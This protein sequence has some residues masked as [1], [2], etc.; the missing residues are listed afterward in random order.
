MIPPTSP[1]FERTRV[2]DVDLADPLPDHWDVAGYRRALILVR[3]R[4]RTLTTVNVAAPDEVVHAAAV[5][6]M[7]AADGWA[8]ATLATRAVRSWLLD[9]D[10]D[11]PAATD[12]PPSWSVVV[13]TRDRA[14]DLRRCLRALTT[15]DVPPGAPAGEI[16]VVDNASADDATARV[17]AE[18]AA[19]PPDARGAARP[20]VRY[21]REDRPGLNWARATGARAARGEIVVYT[22][23]DVVVDPPWIGRMLEPF[24]DSRVAA[25][26]GLTMPLEIETSAQWLFERYGGFGR[27]YTRR[28]F[29]PRHFPP[30]AAGAAGAG[31]NVAFRRSLVVGMRLFDV[32]LDAGTVTLTGGDTYALF[33]LL[34]AGH[35]VVYT[36]DA[37]VWHRHRR[38]YAPLKRTLY[39]YS[40]GGFAF[41]TRCLVEHRDLGAARTALQWVRHDHVRLLARVLLRR[42]SA[43]PRDLVF[44][45]VRGIAVGPWAYLRSRGRERRYRLADAAAAPNTTDHAAAGGAVARSVA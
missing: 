38:E 36:P 41:L 16:V 24:A 42:P 43:L 34:A 27:G 44:A 23:D 32:E 12:A 19:A 11:A 1:H 31:A 9:G 22:D 17:V 26:T 8:R 29:D 20:V 39:G 30:S 33:L 7:I 37:V 40:V 28:V 15:M 4:G 3:W 5:R 2:F 10:G 6:A 14:D 25:V 18:Y 45:Y 13:C 35:H 21:L